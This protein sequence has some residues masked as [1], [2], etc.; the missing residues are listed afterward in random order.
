[1]SLGVPNG[2]MRNGFVFLSFGVLELRVEELNIVR[3]TRSAGAERN[4]R[5]ACDPRFLGFYFEFSSLG[6]MNK[7]LR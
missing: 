7:N 6:L 2:E 3:T 5:D 1:M 4:T